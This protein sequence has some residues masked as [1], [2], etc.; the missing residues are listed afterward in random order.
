MQIS[1]CLKA[2]LGYSFRSIVEGVKLDGQ[3]EGEDDEPSLS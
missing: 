3:L 2:R 1:L